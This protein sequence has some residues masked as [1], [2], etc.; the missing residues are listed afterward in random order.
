MSCF[1]IEYIIIYHDNKWI[2]LTDTQ[3]LPPDEG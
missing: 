3:G 2:I 1:L